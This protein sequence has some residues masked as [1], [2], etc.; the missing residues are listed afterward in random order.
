MVTLSANLIAC[1][2]GVS[3]AGQRLP[4]TLH[5]EQQPRKCSSLAVLENQRTVSFSTV[6]FVPSAFVQCSLWAM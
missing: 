5:P 2:G 6:S 4:G 3:I 1:S